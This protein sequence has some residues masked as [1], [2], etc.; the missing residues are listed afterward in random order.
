MNTGENVI[1]HVERF[2]IYIYSF[3]KNIDD[4]ETSMKIKHS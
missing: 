3:K 2:L 4:N 1:E